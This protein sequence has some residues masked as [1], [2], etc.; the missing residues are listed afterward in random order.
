[1]RVIR[2]ELYYDPDIIRHRAIFD[3]RQADN[4]GL[5]FAWFR[6]EETVQFEELGLVL[7]PPNSSRLLLASANEPRQRGKLPYHLMRAEMFIDQAL[8]GWFPFS[9]QWDQRNRAIVRQVLNAEIV[10]ERS[11]PTAISLQALL[12]KAPG[13]AIG[14][15]IGVQAAG[16]FAPLMLLTVPGG[17]LAVSSAIGV[18]KALEAGLNKR[19]SA[20]LNKGIKG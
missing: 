9:P 17:I 3:E 7:G 18:S 13:V 10:I 12:V 19:I 15:F 8:V 20:F 14:T 16:E 1:M 4:P 6:S 2:T 11:P 5:A